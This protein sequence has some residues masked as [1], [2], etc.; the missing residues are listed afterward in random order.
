[1]GITRKRDAKHCVSASIDIGVITGGERG[2]PTV[3]ARNVASN[4]ARRKEAHRNDCH[5]PANITA[6]ETKAECGTDDHRSYLVSSSFR[7]VI[8]LQNSVAILS[9]PD[10]LHFMLKFRSKEAEQL[11]CATTP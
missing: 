9:R 11:V 4:R 8:G 7:L 2:R 10:R 1:M 6:S 3:C 5:E